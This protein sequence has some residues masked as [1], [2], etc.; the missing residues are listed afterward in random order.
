MRFPLSCVSLVELCLSWCCKAVYNALPDQESLGGERL[1]ISECAPASHLKRA[2]ER[3]AAWFTSAFPLGLHEI[4]VGLVPFLL[5]L[6][7]VV[8]NFSWLGAL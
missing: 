5:L 3:A 7:T 4:P 1:S 6:S 8:W 2:P